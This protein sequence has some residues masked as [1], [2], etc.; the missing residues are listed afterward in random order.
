M[1]ITEVVATQLRIPNVQNI[2]DGTQDVLI[3]EVRTDTGLS[4]FGEVVSSSYVARSV[5]EAPCSGGGRHGLAEILRGMDP[6]D[7]GAAWEAMREGTAWYGRRGVAIHAMAGVDVALWDL[8]AKALGLP[9][10]RA[11]DSQAGEPPRIKAYASVLWGDS[12][13]ETRTL[14]YSLCN[15]RF[16]ALKFGFGLIGTSREYDVAMVQAAREVVGG[17]RDLM[18][19]VGRRWT[20]DDAIERTNAIEPFD[21]GWVEEPLHPD[22]LEGYARLTAAVSVPIAAAETEET[23]PQFEAFLQ[24]GVKV[25]QPDLGR[26]G[27]S[28]GMK[29]AALA[30]TYGARCVPHCFG[31]GINTAASIHWMAA[32]GGD[33]V[34]YPMR[35]NALCRDLASGMPTLDETGCV[36]PGTQAGLGVELNDGIVKEHLFV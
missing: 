11:L 36:T 13:E 9:V 14:A 20:V 23:I 6:L 27:L 24:A 19:D 25:V 22:D 4:G 29:I 34:E 16:R 5:I 12:I 30:R 15:E 28:Q 21:V 10:Y 35:T 33:L 32:A 3:V 8:K 1:R 7:T 17:T 2:F 31:T 26:V 18:V